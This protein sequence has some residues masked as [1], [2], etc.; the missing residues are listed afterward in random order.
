MGPTLTVALPCSVPFQAHGLPDQNKPISLAN[1]DTA[2]AHRADCGTERRKLPAPRRSCRR[3]SHCVP[4]LPPLHLAA[5]PPPLAHYRRLCLYLPPPT[6]GIALRPGCKVGGRKQFETL[7]PS[8]HR[9]QCRRAAPV[10]AKYHPL[11][12]PSDGNQFVGISLFRA[13]VLF[14]SRHRASPQFLS[15]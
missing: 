4:H 13:R 3:R 5:I 1:N 11:G 15:A 6:I 2:A 7:V 12:A 8:A 10:A 14:L 9:T